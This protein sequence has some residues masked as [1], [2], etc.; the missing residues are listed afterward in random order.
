MYQAVLYVSDGTTLVASS[1]INIVV[2][3]TPTVQVTAPNPSLLFRGGQTITAEGTATDLL[4]PEN[5]AVNLEHG[6]NGAQLRWEIVLLH[7]DHTHPLGDNPTGS[8]T[9]PFVVPSTGH[10]FDRCLPVTC[11]STHTRTLSDTHARFCL[12]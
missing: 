9:G 10:T 2:G 1:P 8:S 6:V 5:V 12:R 7:N 3:H 11:L 4:I